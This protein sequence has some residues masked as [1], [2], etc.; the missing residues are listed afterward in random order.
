MHGASPSIY[1]SLEKTSYKKRKDKV[2]AD[3]R[4]EMKLMLGQ[5]ERGR[6]RRRGWGWTKKWPEESG[7]IDNK[8][9][10]TEGE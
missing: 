8:T 10:G 3:D 9:E 2:Q 7:K 1:E 5:P 4:A 6:E